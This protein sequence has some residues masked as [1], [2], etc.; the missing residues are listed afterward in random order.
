MD[1]SGVAL[2]VAL[3]S[4]ASA[5]DAS[6]FVVCATRHRGRGTEEVAMSVL[7][8]VGDVDDEVVPKT[9]TIRDR[10]VS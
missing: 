9:L 5:S 2:T 10:L 7:S 1:G 8:K 4:L 6:S 3:Y